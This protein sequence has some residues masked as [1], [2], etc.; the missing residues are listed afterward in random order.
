MRAIPRLATLAALLLPATSA[1]L[2][3]GAGPAMA[4]DIG[5]EVADA[6]PQQAWTEDTGTIHVDVDLSDPDAVAAV[7]AAFTKWQASPA[8]RAAGVSFTVTQLPLGGTPTGQY[9]VNDGALDDNRPAETSGVLSPQPSRTSATTTLNV[10][11]GLNDDPDAVERIMAHEIGHTFGLPDAFTN[12]ITGL[13]C[14]PGDSVMSPMDPDNPTA[15]LQG[16]TPDDSNKVI[17]GDGYSTGGGTLPPCPPRHPVTPCDPS[18]II[19]D[20]DGSGYHLTDAAHGVAFDILNT[21]HPVRISWTA[22]GSSNAFLVLDRDGNGAITDGAELFGDRTPQAA[23]AGPNGFL[24]LSQFDANHDGVIDARD[25]VFARLRLWQDTDHNGVSSP[26]ELHTLP[27]LGVTAISLRYET[28]TLSDGYANQFRYRA[29]VTGVRGAAW[30][31]DVF[32]TTA[33]STA[34][35]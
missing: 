11:S 25:P 26:A 34:G 4:T 8:G 27:R 17:T 32:F 22:P 7:Q 30:A 35:R 9:L 28:S 5:C 6:N 23:S 1:V 18:P 24:A 14:P 12:S 15:S 20:V 21:G 13:P 16:P 10:G 3:L 33:V 29:L 31:Y 2:V 19:I